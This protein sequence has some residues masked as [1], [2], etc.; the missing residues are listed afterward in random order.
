MTIYDK[1]VLIFICILTE[2]VA[3]VP[4]NTISD[5]ENFNFFLFKSHLSK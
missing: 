2:N 3:N 1:L 5:I 4:N